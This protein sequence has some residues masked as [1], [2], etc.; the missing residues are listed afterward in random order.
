MAY[1]EKA[2][3]L[4]RCKAT[5]KDGA[6]CQAWAMWESE[7]QFCVRHEKGGRGPDRGAERR[8]SL[9]TEIDSGLP[10]E[11]WNCSR[12]KARY[13]PCRCAAY[14][15]PHRPGGGLCRWPDSPLY[16]STRRAGTRPAWK[17]QLKKWRQRFI[18][19]AMR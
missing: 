8:A 15:W 18:G 1:S 5:R 19:R 12:G 10:V 2:R 17:E 13:V 11:F 4:R 6:R 3:E 16:R 14:G 9:L 7:H